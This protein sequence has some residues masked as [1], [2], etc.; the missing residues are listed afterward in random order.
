M[1][2]RFGCAVV[3][4][5]VRGWRHVVEIKYVLGG[6][7]LSLSRSAVVASLRTYYT[8]FALL[9]CT[10]SS[11]K[12]IFQRA[13]AQYTDTLKEGRTFAATLVWNIVNNS[14]YSNSIHNVAYCTFADTGRI[15]MSILTHVI[16]RI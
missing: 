15:S 2:Q 6:A 4:R 10:K 8:M 12:I 11:A 7:I 16:Q 1:L 5:R 14:A 3:W 13:I 9:W